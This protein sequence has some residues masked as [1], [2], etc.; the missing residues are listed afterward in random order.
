MDKEIFDKIKAASKLPDQ[1]LEI[2]DIVYSEYYNTVGRIV[3]LSSVQD[4]PDNP[5]YVLSEVRDPTNEIVFGVTEHNWHYTETGLR[6]SRLIKLNL[7]RWDELPE[8]SIV[9]GEP[10]L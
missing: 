4:L 6:Y 2:D 5:R 1:G 8:Y 7:Q 9:T 10:Q 3:R